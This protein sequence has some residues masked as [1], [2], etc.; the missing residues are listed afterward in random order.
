MSG[1]LAPATRAVLS[2]GAFC[3]PSGCVSR[4][5]VPALII[6]RS[7]LQR[8]AQLDRSDVLC[9]FALVVEAL[10]RSV[11]AARTHGIAIIDDATDAHPLC[12]DLSAFMQVQRACAAQLPVRVV[13]VFTVNAN[14]PT[15]A[16][17]P[18]LR[19][20]VTRQLCARYEVVGGTRAPNLS[21]WFDAAHIPSFLQPDGGLAWSHSDQYGMSEELMSCA[22]QWWPPQ[23]HKHVEAS[24]PQT[25]TSQQEDYAESQAA[26][27]HGRRRCAKWQRVLYKMCGRVVCET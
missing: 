2:L 11:D 4:D 7:K 23:T 16:H 8:N 22:S 27:S 21:E 25:Q 9:A 19:R 26:P 1:S 3:I 14:W 17:T 24:S 12:F 18:F 15:L 13:S 10:L 20:L 6:R 5:G